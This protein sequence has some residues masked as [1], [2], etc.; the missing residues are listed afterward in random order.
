[1]SFSL[2]ISGLNSLKS[3]N[4]LG[5]PCGSNGVNNKILLLRI[6]LLEGRVEDVKKV[7]DELLKDNSYQF[8]QKIISKYKIMIDN[9]LKYGSFIETEY[10]CF[11]ENGNKLEGGYIVFLK[12]T[13]LVED[14]DYGDLKANY[15]PY[16]I[17]KIE[18]NDVYLFPLD[19]NY[20]DSDYKL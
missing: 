1:M 13:P 14:K 8:D 5:S 16:M 3:P 12:S 18:D 19:L 20:N 7:M 9:N 11:I 4:T 17:W 15:R 2:Y 6:Y 10:S